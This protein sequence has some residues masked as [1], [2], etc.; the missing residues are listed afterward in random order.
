MVE[1]APEGCM[2]SHRHELLISS[3]LFYDTAVAILIFS[4]LSSQTGFMWPSLCECFTCCS[5]HSL[6]II[7]V[8]IGRRERANTGLCRGVDLCTIP[9]G[10]SM[11]LI[12]AVYDCWG[13]PC[14]NVLM[15]KRLVHMSNVN[16]CLVIVQVSFVHPSC[17]AY[18]ANPSFPTPVTLI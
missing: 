1:Y 12:M 13:V 11:T 17:K 5:S 7:F 8:M 10:R 16:I 2:I 3:W 4:V 6:L 15:D 14:Q 18:C 9:T